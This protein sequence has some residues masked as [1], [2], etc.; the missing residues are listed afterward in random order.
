VGELYLHT[1]APVS[2]CGPLVDNCAPQVIIELQQ[3]RSQKFFT[4]DA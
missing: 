2:A 3:W 4:G 1:W